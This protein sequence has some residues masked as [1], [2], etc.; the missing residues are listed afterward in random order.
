VIRQ[1][2]DLEFVVLDEEIFGRGDVVDLWQAIDSGAKHM[3][4]KPVLVDLEKLRALIAGLDLGDKKWNEYIDARWLNYV[5]W[6]DS[7]AAY[8]KRRYQTLRCAMVISGAL[9]PA[10]VGLRELQVLGQYGWVFAVASIVA[11]LAVAICAGIE[12][13]FG[14]G[15][16]WREKRA[17]AELIKSEGF[18][19]LQLSG[20]YFQYGTHHDAYK[21]FAKNV[22]DLIRNEIKDYI[23]AVTPKTSGSDTSGSEFFRSPA[24]RDDKTVT[25]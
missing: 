21:F 20:N 10:L 2:L 3:N 15:D 22:E 14:Y 24:Q 6:W 9:I 17:A 8:A 11:S 4:K 16:I 18:S 5:E 1:I 23:V 25:S 19:F 7:R 12:S 13:L